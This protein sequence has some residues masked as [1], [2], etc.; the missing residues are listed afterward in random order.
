LQP[1]IFFNRHVYFVERYMPSYQNVQNN[2]TRG[3]SPQ[4]RMVFSWRYKNG[5][6]ESS[7]KESDEEKSN[8]EKGQKES[9]EE[10]IGLRIV[11]TQIESRH[12]PM[13]AGQ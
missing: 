2:R 1:E 5:K 9:Q 11:Q 6:E 7:K 13:A 12:R 3:M 8:K 4:A 10:K